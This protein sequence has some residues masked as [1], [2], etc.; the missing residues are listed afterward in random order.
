MVISN[1]YKIG[2]SSLINAMKSTISKNFTQ[3]FASTSNYEKTYTT[4]IKDLNLF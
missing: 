3:T 1:L 4:E 2:K